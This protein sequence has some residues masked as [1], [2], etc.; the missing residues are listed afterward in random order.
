MKLKK[1]GFVSRF[2]PTRALRAVPGQVLP[3]RAR[4]PRPPLVGRRPPVRVYGRIGDL[5]V[6]LAGDQ[7]NRRHRN[8]ATLGFK[9][10]WEE[11][12]D[13]AKVV[14]SIDGVPECSHVLRADFSSPDAIER[15]AEDCES[16]AL[17][18]HTYLQKTRE[19]EATQGNGVPGRRWDD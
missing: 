3:F 15:S 6:R 2:S 11:S 9:Y 14:I 10:H 16:L 17:S 19:L 8:V 18:V 5:D 4:L 13:T 7:W 12:E 1:R